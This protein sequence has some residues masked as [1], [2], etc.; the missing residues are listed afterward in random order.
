M[1]TVRNYIR[2]CLWIAPVILG[3]VFVALGAYTI[4]EGVEAKDLVRT[5][6]VDE[7]IV[8]S[9]DASIPGVLVNSAETARAE[10]LVLKEHTW[11]EYGPYTEMERGDP[12]RDSYLNALT[13]RNSLNLAVM[14]LR[15]SDLV[16]GVG[17]LIVVLGVINVV[18]VA[19]ML[20]WTRD[21]GDCGDCGRGREA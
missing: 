14:G 10:A 15:M 4:R 1:A 20:R 21:C 9:D 7:R 16:V 8:T 5:A 3:L 2:D 6:L 19:P 17:T 11:G 13:M 18:G 12:N